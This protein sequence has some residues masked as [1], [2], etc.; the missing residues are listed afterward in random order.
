MS[1]ESILLIGSKEKFTLDYIYYKS[2]KQLGYDVEFLNID[3]ALKNRIVAKFNS[4]FPIFNYE[5]LRKKIFFFFKK[6]KKKYSKII[7]FKGIYLDDLTVNKIRKLQSN[8]TWIN[9]FPDDP[10]NFSNSS[11]SNRKFFKTI[12]LFDYFCIW[13]HKIKRKLDKLFPRNNFIYLP[14]A[15]NSLNKYKI[16]KKYRE[17][18]NQIIFIGTY[19]AERLKIIKN[20]KFKKKI[21]GGNWKRIVTTNLKNTEIGYHLHGKKLSKLIS[22]SKITLNI[23]RKQNYASHNMKTFEIPGNNGLMLTTRSKEQNVFFKENKAC[24]MYSN[25]KELNKKIKFIINNPKKSEK[26]RKYGNMLIKKH[27][28]LNR[29][30]FLMNKV[31]ELNRN[32]KQ[33]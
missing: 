29:I 5:S 27:N 11:I 26:V 21:Y 16:N 3:K 12:A 20:I 19:D 30:K 2:F 4:I 1:K 8:S 31:N 9:I 23:L 28:Y 6:K 7:V 17:N 18:K 32:K 14:F 15:Y 10:F 33:I 13:S 22:Q 25:S 24:Y